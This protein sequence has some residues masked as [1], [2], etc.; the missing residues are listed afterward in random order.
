MALFRV[1]SNPAAILENFEWP[2]LRNGSFYPLH[3]KVLLR[4]CGRVF[5]GTHI[6]YSAHRTIIFAIAQ[7]SCL[8]LGLGLFLNLRKTVASRIITNLLKTKET[9]GD[10]HS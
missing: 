3:V 6:L 10:G 1:I 2:Y 8:K 4:F 7:L 5:Q 9:R